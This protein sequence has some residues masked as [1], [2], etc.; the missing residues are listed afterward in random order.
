M[1]CNEK[2]SRPSSKGVDRSGTTVRATNSEHTP[3]VYGRRSEKKSH[4]L[5]TLEK[6]LSNSI[7]REEEHCARLRE[8]KKALEERVARID[9]ELVR[10][11]SEL[12]E[13]MDVFLQL[14]TSK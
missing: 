7:T 11:Q 13:K 12:N 8:E 6:N 14:Y 5:L 10:L 4:V 3:H 1:Q 9:D 2:T